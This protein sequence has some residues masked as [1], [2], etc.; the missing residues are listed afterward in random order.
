MP[1]TDPRL[2]ARVLDLLSQFSESIR[3]RAVLYG[4]DPLPLPPPGAQF[5]T[6]MDAA[7]RRSAVMVDCVSMTIQSAK[8]TIWRMMTL[9]ILTLFPR[10]LSAARRT[11]LEITEI[12][13]KEPTTS[14]EP[15]EA[16]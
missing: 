2:I 14:E 16:R 15:I 12:E 11:R 5:V 4:P 6:E 7:R 8:R 10:K 9:L 13:K 1:V 3:F